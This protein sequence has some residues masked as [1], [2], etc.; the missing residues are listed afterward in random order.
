M[1]D[2]LTQLQH[3]LNGVSHML[4]NFIGQAARDA[5]PVAVGDSADEKVPPSALNLEED[6]RVKADQLMGGFKHLDTLIQALPDDLGA[7]AE[8]LQELQQ[9]CRQ[10]ADAQEQLRQEYERAER[11]LQVAQDLF[12][13][14]AMATL[15][16]RQAR[17]LQQLKAEI[18]QAP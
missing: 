4:F 6:T 16:Q 1:S 13:A 2:P 11:K 3:G 5:P 14:V 17:K 15:Q 7:E 10:N 9:L 8:Q 12:G 18:S